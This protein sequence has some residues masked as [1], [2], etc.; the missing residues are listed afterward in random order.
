MG[1]GQAG[2]GTSNERGNT[3]WYRL[4]LCNF[5]FHLGASG[6]GQDFHAPPCRWLRNCT[7]GK[8]IVYTVIA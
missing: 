3:P 7:A 2:A 8:C 1:G 4:I 6:W 5:R